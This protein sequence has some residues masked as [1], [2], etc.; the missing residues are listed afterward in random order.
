ME[1]K[2]LLNKVVGENDVPKGTVEAKPVV[3]AGVSIKTKK[4]DGTAM[5]TPMVQFSVIHPDKEDPMILSKAQYLEGKKV[6][7]KGFWVQTDDDGNFYKGSTV[8]LLLKKLGCNTLKEAETKVV[9]TI[10]ESDDSPYLCF[11]LF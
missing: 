10:A 8:D 4:K 1:T 6:V 5:D 3:I 7:T 2:D 9:E 11:K